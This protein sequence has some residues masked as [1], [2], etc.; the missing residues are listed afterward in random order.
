[1]TINI[2]AKILNASDNFYIAQCSIFNNFSIINL[3]SSAASVDNFNLAKFQISNLLPNTKYYVRICYSNGV[4]IDN[5]VGSFKTP[6]SGVYSFKLGFASCSFSS[7]VPGPGVTASNQIIYDRIAQ[8]A[9]NNEIDLFLHLGD[10][11]YSDI[12]TNNEALFHQSYD[13]VFNAPRQNNCWKNLPMYYMWDD[14]DYG[15][16]DGSKLNPSRNA[17]I[18]AYRR[19]VPYSSI[20]AKNGNTDSPYYSFVRGRAR[21]IVTD[22][23]SEREEKGTYPSTDSR[24]QVLSPDQKS[25]FFSEMLAAKN[26]SQIIVWVNTK[27]W[28]SSTGDGKDDWGGYHAARL[29][30]VDFINQNNLRDRIVILS[31]DMHALAFDDGSSIN[32]YGSLKVCHAAALDQQARPKGGPY[33]LGP[34]TND[35]G[36]GWV[37]QYGVI[38]IND[39]GNTSI[40]INF[41]GIV[42]SKIDFTESIAIDVSFDLIAG[43]PISSSSSSSSSSSGSS[44][45][46]DQQILCGSI[47]SFI[48]VCHNKQNLFVNPLSFLYK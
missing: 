48:N 37:T 1:M 9:I 8:K 36:T 44:E 7:S 47:V 14:H 33:T 27:P 35:S 21:F 45:G 31:G 43:I 11:H 29:E 42:V 32:N 25:W 18:A 30:I 17:A 19:R 2:T 5:Y 6:V 10:M 39:T 4:P 28:I 12:S 41:K 23:R 13:G 34:I 15:P 22:I 3:T 24:Q 16:N 40:N 46:A 20:L 26:N 38:E